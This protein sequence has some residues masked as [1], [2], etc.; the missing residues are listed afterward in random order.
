MNAAERKQAWKQA[1]AA[2]RAYSRD[3]SENNAITVENA[4][5]EIRRMDSVSSGAN[6]RPPGCRLRDPMAN[7]AWTQATADRLSTT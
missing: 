1:R 4:W 5:R 7:M 2:V 6:G 3:P